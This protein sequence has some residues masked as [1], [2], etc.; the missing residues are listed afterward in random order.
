MGNRFILTGKSLKGRPQTRSYQSKRRK[1]AAR[2][3]SAGKLVLGQ[4]TLVY[5]A[6]VMLLVMGVAYLV[7][8]NSRV[9]K[10]FEIAQ[11]EKKISVLKKSNQT[12]ERQV[13]D[14]QSIQKIQE[15]ADVEGFVQ[16][17]DIVYIQEEDYA[18]STL[19]NP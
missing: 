2:Y 10:A 3:A 12:M 5:S 13:A 11:M 8:I 4:K 17:S 6:C 1:R 9:S 7:L 19:Q 14:L 18:F 16:A 15:S